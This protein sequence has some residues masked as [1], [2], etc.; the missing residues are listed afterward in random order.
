MF[1]Q[2]VFIKKNTPELRNKMKELGYRIMVSAE[3]EDKPYLF[4]SFGCLIGK[5]FEDY[6][7]GIHNCGTNEELFVAI[8]ALRSD[9]DM[10]QWFKHNQLDE[11]FY[12][13]YDKFHLFTFNPLD[14]LDHEDLSV[15]YHKATV[16]ELIEYFK[17][18]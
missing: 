10:D 8:A 15:E 5:Q 7:L 18:K 11:F 17:D 1:T 14:A 3:S 16:F 4:T 12:C 9:T 13:A 6:P 2:S